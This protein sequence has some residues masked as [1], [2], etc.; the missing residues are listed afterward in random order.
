MTTTIPSS[1]KSP[2][3]DA[4]PLIEELGDEDAR[5][6]MRLWLELA[7][8]TD[9]PGVLGALA[10]RD[11]MLWRWLEFM[12]RY[13]LVVM[14]TMGDLAPPH[15]LRSITPFSPQRARTASRTHCWRR[16]PACD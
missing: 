14:P 13:P 4:A 5:T 12:Q 2:P 1:A 6:S 16:R 3:L 15:N 8:P 9:M 10:Q 11:L 7:P